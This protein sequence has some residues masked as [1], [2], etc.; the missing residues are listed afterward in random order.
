MNKWIEII[1][2]GTGHAI[3]AL[4]EVHE[5]LAKTYIEAGFAKDGGNGPNKAL[6]LVGLDTLQKAMKGYNEGAAEVFKAAAE[7]M[8][9]SVKFHTIEAGESQ[10]D[11]SKSLGDFIKSIVAAAQVQDLEACQTAQDRLRKVYVSTNRATSGPIGVR[12]GMEES[13]GTLGGFWTA[14]ETYEKS[15]LMEQVEDAAIL[16]G[17]TT[18]PLTSR[19]HTWPALNQYQ[20]PTKGNSAMLGGVTVSRSGEITQRSKTQPVP[21]KVKLEANDLVA[22]TQFS[23]DLMADDATGT[24]T[25]MLTMLIGG[26]IGFRRDYEHIWGTGL[27]QPMGIMNSP[28]LMTQTRNTTLIV[29]WTD[30]AKMLSR[31]TPQARKRAVVVAH[32]YHMET[33]LEMQDPAGHYIY[34]PNFP[35]NN[36][37]Q[38]QVGGNNNTDILGNLPVIYSEKMAAPGT[39]GDFL[40]VDRKAILSGILGGLEFGLSEHFLFDTDQVALRCKIRD[41]AQPWVVAPFI[42]ADGVGTNKVSPFQALSTL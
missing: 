33:L 20:A 2:D 5:T 22:F 19:A 24:L 31:L 25:M 15:I 29:K 32:P 17:V 11:K 30:F 6:E 10:A 41:D 4:L 23:R 8:R 18:V 14:P 40:L 1:K 42:I 35:S 12:K 37:G 34:I 9:K 13:T 16:P 7:D 36:R 38:A 28:A 39:T 26:A 3:G 21:A 27:G